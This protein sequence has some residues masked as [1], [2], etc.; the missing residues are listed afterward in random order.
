MKRTHTLAIILFLLSACTSYHQEGSVNFNESRKAFNVIEPLAD[1]VSTLQVKLRSRVDG[2]IAGGQGVIVSATTII[3]AAHV[4]SHLKV[5]DELEALYS[6]RLGVR[7]KSFTVRLKYI[8]HESEVAVLE[9]V[10]VRFK[11]AMIAPL[12]KQSVGGN[13]VLGVKE[14]FHKKWLSSTTVYRGL[15]TNITELPLVTVDYDSRASKGGFSP[16]LA[17]GQGRLI[18]ITIADTYSGN[19][20]GALFDKDQKCVVAIMSMKIGLDSLE[21]PKQMLMQ[22]DIEDEDSKLVSAGFMVGIPIS[23]FSKYISH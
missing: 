23:H 4:L 22:L 10:N 11:G 8:D 13:N 2:L 7:A 16:L 1:V 14:M 12:C 15:T 6:P 9:A 21:H 18:F 20:G 17:Q 19:S 5:G 3:T